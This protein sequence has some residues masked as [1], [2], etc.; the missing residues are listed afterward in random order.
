M[1]LIELRNISKRFGKLIVL[2]RFSLSIE[3]G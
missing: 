3:T 1:S 2:D